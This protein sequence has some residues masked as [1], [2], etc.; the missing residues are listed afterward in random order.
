MNEYALMVIV[1]VASLLF[2]LVVFDPKFT[3]RTRWACF[4]IACLLFAFEIIMIVL[5]IRGLE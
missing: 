3:G 4:W 2:W 5:H 1:G